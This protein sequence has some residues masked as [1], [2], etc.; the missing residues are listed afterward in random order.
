MLATTTQQYEVLRFSS[1]KK[2]SL[3]QVGENVQITY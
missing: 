2:N 3:G 1:G